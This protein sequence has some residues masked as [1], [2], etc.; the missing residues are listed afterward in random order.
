MASL[1]LG[2]MGYGRLNEKVANLSE[3]LK[4]LPD[5]VTRI[6]AMH[7][8]VKEMKKDIKLITKTLLKNCPNCKEE[9]L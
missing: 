3:D 6:E 5:R 2:A 1:T 7:N 4:G 8:D 9:D